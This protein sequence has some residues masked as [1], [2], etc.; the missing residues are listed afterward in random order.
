VFAFLI[1]FDR[2]PLSPIILI[3]GAVC[4]VV[5]VAVPI[6]ASR[7]RLHIPGYV[8]LALVSFVV[9]FILGRISGVHGVR[10]TRSGEVL[11]IVFF[12]LIAV[13]V[14]SVLAIFFH[15]ETPPG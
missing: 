14:G 5:V 4:I 13:S 3:L 7:G 9:A 15:R 1:W 2:A 10:G 8:G 11:S 12:V 6:A